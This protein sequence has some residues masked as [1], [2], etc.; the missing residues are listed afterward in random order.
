MTTQGERNPE[1]TAVYPPSSAEIKEERR[2]YQDK[3]A[4]ELFKAVGGP[5]MAQ[6]HATMIRGLSKQADKLDEFYNTPFTNKQVK[7][8]MATVESIER[9]GRELERWHHLMY[10]N[11][12]RH[13]DR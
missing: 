6:A 7:T 3:A 13:R 12:A 11:E 1:I 10:P 8:I 5:K 2:S 4:A 9:L